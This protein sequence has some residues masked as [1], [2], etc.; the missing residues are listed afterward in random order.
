MQ[1]IGEVMMQ[2]VYN[3]TK[4]CT[5][6]NC[7]KQNPLSVFAVNN[8]SLEETL[9]VV[10]PHCFAGFKVPLIEVSINA[11]NDREKVKE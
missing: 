4:L 11:P 10:C 9:D 7:R 2:L 8:L 6:P 3:A 1:L 5:C